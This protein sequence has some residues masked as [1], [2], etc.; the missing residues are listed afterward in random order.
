MTQTTP[1]QERYSRF[2]SLEPQYARFNYSG[3]CN[4]MSEAGR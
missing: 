4:R 1:A 2:L 3:K